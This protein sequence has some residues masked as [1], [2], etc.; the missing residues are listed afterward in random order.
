YCNAKDEDGEYLNDEDID[1]HMAFLLFAAF[2]TTTSALTN[3][4]YYLGK[5]PEW[6][7]KVRN[8]IFS[9]KNEMPTFD[10]VYRTWYRVQNQTNR[11]P[12]TASE[13]RPIKLYEMHIEKH[14]GLLPIGQIRRSMIMKVME[15][16]FIKNPPLAD[17]LLSY[18][19]EVLATAVVDRL[20]DENPCPRKP[21]V[22]LIERR[23]HVSKILA[24]EEMPALM[25]WLEDAP[26]SEA[27][28]V[29]M[30]MA[31]ITAQKARVIVAME[32][33][34]FDLA[35]GIWTFPGPNLNA[36]KPACAKLIRVFSSKLPDYLCSALNNL[37]ERRSS[38]NFV[39]S[40][41]G[42]KPFHST[43]LRQ[44]FQK[45]DLVKVLDFR[46]TFQ[47]WC[48]HQ[49]PPVDANLIARYI[50]HS[51]SGL[52]DYTRRLDMFNQRMDLAERYCSF[53]MKSVEFKL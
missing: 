41:D 13:R 9:I 27:M 16:I 52:E 24:H 21:Q 17:Y 35:S 12:N 14:I 49:T 53:V 42:K 4:L 15:P 43:V 32:W 44:N 51:R 34:H 23:H 37:Y 25:G 47:S 8:E 48:L 33:Q 10:D 39:F 6:Q 19:S 7:D 22:P 29:A 20:I 5:N 31:V 3:I 30:R 50:E 46:T 11:W 36:E 40:V 45:C 18:L 28:K 2:D 38:D 26:L 1:G